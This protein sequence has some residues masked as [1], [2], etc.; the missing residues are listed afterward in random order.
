MKQPEMKTTR[1]RLK[2][3]G[4][5]PLEVTGHFRILDADGKVLKKEGPVFLCRCGQSSNKPYCDGSHKASGFSS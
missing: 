1:A 4:S 5:G 2:V 3:I